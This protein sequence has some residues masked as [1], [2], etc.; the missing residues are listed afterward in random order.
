MK[1]GKKALIGLIFLFLAVLGIFTTLSAFPKI[2]KAQTSVTTAN[3]FEVRWYPLVDGLT[4]KEYLVEIQNLDSTTNRDFNLSVIIS[5]TSFPLEKV[6]NLWVYEWKALNQSFPT[7]DVRVV[8]ATYTYNATNTTNFT[9]PTNCNWLNETPQ[10]VADYI[11]FYNETYQNGTVWK[12]KND[13]KPTK[14]ALITQPDKVRA[15]Y[16][17][18][19]IPKLGS[20]EKYDDFGD[21]E[22]VN[23][24]KKF[25]IAFDVPITKL[26]NGWGSYG[27]VGILEANSNEFYHP[28]WNATWQY[29]KPITIN[30]TQNTN[31][32]T[33]YQ[34][35]INLT[36]SSNMQP[37]FSDIRFTWYNSTDGSEI[38]IPYWI[39]SKVNSTWAYVWV[40]VP[41][42]P[43]SS[44][45]TIYVYYGNTTPVSS[46][47]NPNTTIS[48]LYNDT[49]LIMGWNF[50]EGSGT[51]SINIQGN[52]SYDLILGG[53]SWLP[54]VN[55]IGDITVP[56]S[57]YSLG[58]AGASSVHT[59]VNAPA[60]VFTAPVSWVA[61]FYDNRSDTDLERIVVADDGNY[62][63]IAA[64][65]NTQKVQCQICIGPS[66]CYYTP[67]FTTSLNN[68]YHIACVL[69]ST[70]LSMYVNATYFSSVAVTANP[71]NPNRPISIGYSYNPAGSYLYGWVDDVGIY[72]EELSAKKIKALYE[73]RK[74]TDPE[75]TYSIGE[76]EF[77]VVIVTNNYPTNN[78]EV[79]EWS[80]FNATAY[81]TSM[82]ATKISNCTLYWNES[83]SMQPVTTL[84]EIQNNTMF[85]VNLTL[86]LQSYQFYWSCYDDTNHQ[87][88][89]PTWIV[90]S[91][92]NVSG[93][94]LDENNNPL[95]NI[96][97]LLIDQ[98]TNQVE[99]N[100]TS[101]LDGWWWIKIY[102]PRNYTIVAYDPT[103]ST[104]AGSIKPW[105]EV[106]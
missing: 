60:R 103:N 2:S 84:T 33:D 51:T 31:T 26:T 23:G 73:R 86:K 54:E 22:T 58:F 66:T 82:G 5:N 9:L 25:K 75:P 106:S 93:Q 79:E 29:R 70:T 18:I 20:K 89:S 97:V 63:G 32:L 35:A 62:R 37:D 21:V 65:T 101:N 7:Y 74:Y 59:P 78:G 44:Y 99:F 71:A 13:W 43:A 57:G 105:V 38:E 28:W 56:L 46:V 36:Y 53:F 55:R 3:D 76:E 80:W 90:T 34:V 42:I 77:S 48:K 11:C 27:L 52:S 8:N 91:F 94:T 24:T 69:N 92:R 6:S 81:T 87:G 39:E 15:D 102:T 19:N 100:L 64:H 88:Q 16:G 47:S 14:M 12:M 30:N 83:G 85:G 40:K 61:W 1:I 72:A 68:W 104:R 4:H 10:D 49:T 50:D 67:L 17:V 41:Y 96:T 98:A 95:A 45:T